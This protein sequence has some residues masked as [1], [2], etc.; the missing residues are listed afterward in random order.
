MP[1]RRL[2]VRGL[3]AAAALVSALA[4]RE[5]TWRPLAT[6]GE[7]PDDGFTRAIGVV[8]VH[9]TLSDGGGTPEEVIAAAQ[10]AGLDFIF[11]TDHNNLDAK[12]HEGRHGR[13][14]V[15]VGAEIST[16]AGHLLALGIERPGYRFWG[17]PREALDDVRALGGVAFAAHPDSPRQDLRFTAW[18]AAGPFGLEVYNGDS[19]WRA[20]GFWRG[21]RTLLAYPLHADRALL[22]SLSPV[23]ATLQRWDTLSRR[24]DVAMIAGA[25][26]HG[27]IALSRARGDDGRP[28]RGTS[29]R[30]PAYAALFRQARNHVVLQAPLTGQADADLRSLAT[31]LGRGRSY[32]ALDALADGRDFS[33]TAR[34]GT[35]RATMGDTLAPASDLTW[36]AGGRLPADALIV[37][38]RDGHEQARAQ[39][40][41]RH[42]AAQPG[43]YRVEVRLPGWPMP[44]IVTN[45]IYVF[46]PPTAA[47]RRAAAAWPVDPPPPARVS[48]LDDFEQATIFHAEVDPASSIAEPLSVDA[49]VPEV[50]PGHPG[51]TGRRVGRF[52]FRLGVPRAGG[53]P[54]PWCALMQRGARD[55]S[56]TRGLTF[57]LRA[58]GV[59]RFALLVRDRN[60]RGSDDG[61]ESWLASIRTGSAWRRVVL[62]WERFRS[63]D[64][65]SDGRLDLEHVVALGLL[66]DEL[67][68]PPGSAGTLWLDDLATY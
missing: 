47:L 51:P 55:L 9:T 35:L 42:A 37:L 58:D 1:S 60:P 24:R 34:T 3:L 29:L 54:H 33:F 63:L 67:S 16:S 25:D 21:L 26:A 17:D 5:V 20:A 31:A 66:V 22:R 68:Q 46:D 41:L 18:D 53:P 30:W 48:L 61:Q 13:L 8:H 23:D 6:Q 19:Q 65:G 39:G 59:Y 4:L 14:L 62:P 12:P 38:L 57:L 11:L 7:P 43:V 64:P 56:G 50:A 49:T 36:H 40:A 52:A 44:W 15:G 27:R 32:T 10:Q 45:P 2:L 28:T